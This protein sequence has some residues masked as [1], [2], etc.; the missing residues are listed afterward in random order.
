MELKFEKGREKNELLYCRFTY[1][2]YKYFKIK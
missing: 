2:T 1:W